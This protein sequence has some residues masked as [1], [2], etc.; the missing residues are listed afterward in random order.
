MSY[1][2]KTRIYFNALDI[3]MQ[4]VGAELFSQLNERPHDLG[5]LNNIIMSY[6][7]QTRDV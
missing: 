4:M 5:A 7:Q 2:I 3:L 1:Y 6:G